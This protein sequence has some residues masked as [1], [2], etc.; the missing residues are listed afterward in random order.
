MEVSFE[1]RIKK[2]LKGTASILALFSRAPALSVP[3][4]MLEIGT[5]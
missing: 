4:M 3:M 5:L 1:E 2:A